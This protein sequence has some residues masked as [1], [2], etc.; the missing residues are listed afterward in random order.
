[1]PDACHALKG[2]TSAADN[3]PVTTPV[4]IAWGHTVVGLG[5]L[6]RR[7]AFPAAVLAL[8]ALVLAGATPVG[9]GV[10]PAWVLALPIAVLLGG[11]LVAIA[12]GAVGWFVFPA[13][14]RA[15]LSEVTSGPHLES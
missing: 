7:L 9:N 1:M 15:V 14:H 13:D 6:V 3:Y 4:R 11:R 12:L 2:F 10:S 8:A 5:L